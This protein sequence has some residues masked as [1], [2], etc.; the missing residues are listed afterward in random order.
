MFNCLYGL[1][2]I[3]DVGYF[4]LIFVDEVVLGDLFNLRVYGF[5]CLVILIYLVMDN[6]YVEI[7]FFFVFN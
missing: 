5:G 1:K 3:F 4:V 7:F 6:L 2:I